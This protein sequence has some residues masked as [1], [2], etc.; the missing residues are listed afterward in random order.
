LASYRLSISAAFVGAVV[1]VNYD[2]G[3]RSNLLDHR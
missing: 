1:N 2:A 3:Q